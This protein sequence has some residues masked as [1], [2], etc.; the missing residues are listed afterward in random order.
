MP[1][2]TRLYCLDKLYYLLQGEDAQLFSN[3]HL[4]FKQP[5]KL[6]DCIQAKWQGQDVLFT[7]NDQS[8][9]QIGK[10]GELI[11]SF[12]EKTTRL[13]EACQWSNDLALETRTFSIRQAIK[14]LYASSLFVY[15]I[16][17]MDDICEWDPSE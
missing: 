9:L 7:L 12:P 6:M 2:L 10:S 16:N 14:T 1:D 3:E 4:V 13:F 17:K 8:R 11:A 5:G 15:T